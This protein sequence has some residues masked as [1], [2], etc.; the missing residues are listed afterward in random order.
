MIARM[1]AVNDT[2]PDE[3]HRLAMRAIVMSAVNEGV[4]ALTNNE[5]NER[6]EARRRKHQAQG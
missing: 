2:N 4:D 5:A 3:K 1:L 6:S